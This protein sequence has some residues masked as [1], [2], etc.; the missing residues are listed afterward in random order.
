MKTHN[1]NHLLRF[2]FVRRLHW[3]RYDVY[4]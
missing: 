1:G 2:E 4:T 3:S